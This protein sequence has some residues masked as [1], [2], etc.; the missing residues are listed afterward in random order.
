MQLLL[1]TLINL[2]KFLIKICPFFILAWVVASLSACQGSQLGSSLEGAISP[3]SKSPEPEASEPIAVNSVN[4]TPQ[5][6]ISPTPQV[7]PSDRPL[8]QPITSNTNPKLNLDRVMAAIAVQAIPKE[9]NQPS[10]T[11]YLAIKFEA[12]APAVNSFSDISQAPNSLQPWLK[13]LNK[14]G[15]IEPKIRQEFQPNILIARREY[16]RWLF[17]TNNRLYQKQPSRQIRFAQPTD[18]PSFADIPKSHPDFAIVQG[19][20][21][22]GLITGDRFRPNDPLLREELVQ[23][24]IPLDIR[25]PLPSA[26][27]ENIEQLWGFQDSDRISDNALRSIFA[28]GQLGD[29]ANI[30]RSFGFTTILQP[31]KPVTRAEAAASLWYFGTVIDGISVTKALEL[32]GLNGKN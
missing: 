30:R 3:A 27:V 13:D 24:K 1:K 28:D 4:P 21:N 2:I 11:D 5:P 15:T 9:S 8:P 7:I 14:L 12:I 20:A 10:L 25:Q 6:T 29:L 22:A 18:N 16:A 26:N 31:Q 17:K 32:E 19:L 23:W